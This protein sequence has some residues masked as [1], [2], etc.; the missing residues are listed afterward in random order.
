VTKIEGFAV[1][2]IIHINR[3]RLKRQLP[4]PGQTAFL[5]QRIT[6]LLERLDDD[7]AVADEILR[8]RNEIWLVEAMTWPKGH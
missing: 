8:L 1:G 6:A 7:P 2:D 4:I 3:A 5:E